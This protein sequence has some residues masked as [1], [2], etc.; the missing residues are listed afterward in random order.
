MSYNMRALIGKLNPTA[1]S[2]MEGADWIVRVAHALQ[3]RVPSLPCQADGADNTDADAHLPALSASISRSSRGKSRSRLD[4][5][6]R[7]N[8]GR[9]GAHPRRSWNC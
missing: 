7:G 1:R 5:M 3:R 9:T 4:K 2:V 6:K 8:T